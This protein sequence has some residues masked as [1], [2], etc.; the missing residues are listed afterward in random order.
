MLNTLNSGFYT[1]DRDQIITSVR[2]KGTEAG[3]PGASR[4]L[5]K[6]IST[7]AP[8]PDQALVQR[9]QHQRA[10]EGQEVTWVWPVG[11][12]AWVR[13]HVA[14]LKDGE[15]AV[16]GAAGFWRDETA[17]MRAREEEDSRWNRFRTSGP[18]RAS[19]ETGSGDGPTE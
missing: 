3:S 15:G 4:L 8:S 5:G 11:S 2:G 9:D 6:P 7:I 19:G 18:L 1:I 16:I 12:G 17:I 13:S 14:P 10:L